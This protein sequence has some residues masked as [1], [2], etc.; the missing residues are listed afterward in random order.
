[1]NVE[2]IGKIIRFHRKA[3]GLSRERCG[4]LA[5]VGKTIIYDIE[6]GKETVQLKSL[7]KILQVLNIS[8]ELH[9]PIMKNFTHADS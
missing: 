9:S 6:H 1:M 8:I 3:A 2:F 4:Q 5:G 7:L